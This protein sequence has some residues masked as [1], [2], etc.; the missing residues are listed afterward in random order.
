[1]AAFHDT[2][3]PETSNCRADTSGRQ[4]GSPGSQHTHH[5]C[6]TGDQVQYLQGTVG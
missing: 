2:F 5:I 3:S 1:M 4:I 6:H